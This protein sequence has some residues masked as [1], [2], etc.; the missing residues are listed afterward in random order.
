MSFAIAFWILA[1]LSVLSALAVV[2]SRNIFRAA[3]LLGFCFLAVAGVYVL[4]NADFL[5][6]VQVLIY[7]GAVSILIILAVMLTRDV[8]TGSVNNRLRVPA[9]VLSV[10]L[11][12]ALAYSFFASPWK[13]TSPS[14]YSSGTGTTAD[15]ATKF[16]GPQ[17]Y[18]LPV[19]IVAVLLL[20]SA[21]GAIVLAR[22]K[23]GK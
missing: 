9:L 19:E 7:I 20:V 18:I 21:V 3:L 16:F 5:A 12:A 1:A 4:L 14:A 6:A 23:E 22:E 2:I 13:V 15:L 17:G 8:T 10:L 11:F